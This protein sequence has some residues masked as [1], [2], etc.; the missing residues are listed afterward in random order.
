MKVLLVNKFHYRKGGSETYYFTLAKALKEAGHEV[1]FF[2]M[3]SE[4]NIPCEQEKYFVENV[5]YNGKTNPLKQLSMAKK[6]IYSKEAKRKMAELIEDE[7]PDLAIFNLVHR[8]LSLSIIEPLKK[9]KIPIFWVTHDLIFACP[10]YTMLDNNGDICEKCMN[11]N[12]KYCVKKKCIK[13]SFLKSYLAYKE[14]R[15]IKEHNYYNDIDLYICPSL[16][17]KNKL[18][19]ANF[20]TSL[21]IHLPNPL[22]M[23][24]NIKIPTLDEIKDYVLYFGRISKEKGVKT[25]IDAVIAIPERKLK[26]LGTGPL[27]KELKEYVI[28]KKVDNRIKFL[29]FKSGDELT[30]YIREA[31]VVVL[32]S[33]WYEN[34]PYS[35]M[36]ALYNGKPLIVSNL[37][38]LPEFIS[39][40]KK[41]YKFKNFDNNDLK[42]KIIQLY[43]MDDNEYL[44][45]ARK[46]VYYANKEFNSVLYVKRIIQIYSQIQ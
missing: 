16:F 36:E 21:I 35:A 3:K 14:A 43:S 11:G 23:D 2:A 5:E 4:H 33:E 42:N 25:L 32:P 29:G 45:M 44:E 19:E 7:K 39:S 6:T 10:N 24:E 41:G 22:E 17:Y 31:K 12:F 46:C 9:N 13:G 8:Q 34:G 28:S 38:G 40:E 15:F 1:I 37:G 18:T 27:E 20:T 30:K 26:I